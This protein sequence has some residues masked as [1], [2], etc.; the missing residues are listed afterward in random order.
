MQTLR[1]STAVSSADVLV[2]ARRRGGCCIL[3]RY[4]FRPF[5]ERL[6]GARG[7][8]L[9]GLDI[10]QR[11]PPAQEEPLILPVGKRGL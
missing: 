4:R 10:D 9:E 3:W 11:T 2:L 5:C 6:H 1:L 8:L 7:D